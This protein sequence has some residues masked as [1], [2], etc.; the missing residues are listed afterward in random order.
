MEFYYP[1]RVWC[2]TLKSTLLGNSSGQNNW[3]LEGSVMLYLH[4]QGMETI[5]QKKRDTLTNTIK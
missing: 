1:M 5:I 3:Y 4:L 2:E